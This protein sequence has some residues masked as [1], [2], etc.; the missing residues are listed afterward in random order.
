M[1][2]AARK[3][4]RDTNK[5]IIGFY[6][7]RLLCRI[8]SEGNPRFILKGGQSQLAR[9]ADARETK[10]IDLVGMT[11]EIEQALDDLKELASVDL[12]DYID[13]QFLK[14]TL[15]PVS[16]EYRTGMRVEFVPVLEKTKRLSVIGIDLVV[17]Q[18][19]PTDFVLTPPISRLDI[20]GLVTYDYA[21]Q[22]I[23]ERV[24]DKVC[25]IMQVY[26]GVPSS[27]VKDLVDLVVSKAT[28][29]IDA[30]A[31]LKRLR[32][33]T[34]LR[35]MGHINEIH[36][37][38]DWKTIRAAAYKKEAQSACVPSELTDAAN[39]ETAI[40][41]WLGPVLRGELPDMKWNPGTQ[42]WEGAEHHGR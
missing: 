29:S 31:F 28:D 24:A 22:T 26:E 12:H 23:E 21:L 20:A 40:A 38:A 30:D 6:R 41:S 25:A 17:D 16:Q 7:D 36:I 27:R 15:I 14:A 18:T 37:P 34:T 11:T 33:E 39:A 3:S 19:P 1:R 4:R 10:D 32:R 5:E 8:F 9:R 42:S 35:H 2:A 13:F